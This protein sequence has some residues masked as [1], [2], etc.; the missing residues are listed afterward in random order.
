MKKTTL[1][2]LAILA[3][4]ACH[5]VEDPTLQWEQA[6]LAPP[7]DL[8]LIVANPQREVFFGDLHIHSSYSF[9]AYTMGVRAFPEDAYRFARG[10]QVRHGVGYPVQIDRPLDF[11]AVSDHSE[12]LGIARRQAELDD[13]GKVQETYDEVL[14]TALAGR[15]WRYLWHFMREGIRSS[16]AQARERNF[17]VPELA[18]ASVNAWAD[19][20]RAAQVHNA[21]GRFT[22]FV[23]YEWS[24]MPED[25]HLHRVVLYGDDK[26]PGLPWSS[27]ESEN[28]EDLWKEL[29]RQRDAGH[30]V[31][32]IPHNSNLSNGLMFSASQHSG[33]P[34]KEAL[35]AL[36]RSI[37]PV[38]EIYQVKGQSETHPALSPDDTFADFELV[39]Q[40]VMA[41]APARETRG[42]YARDALRLGME[43]NH[44]AGINPYR[45]GVIGSS[46]SHNATSPVNEA[47]Y[48]GK[49]PLLDGTPGI[50]LGAY[51]KDV[52]EQTT[53]HRWSAMG[54]A[55]VWAPENTR[56]ALFAAMNRKETYA[57]SGS[58]IRLRFFAGDYPDTLIDAADVIEV[59]Y[60][61]GVPMGGE[62]HVSHE[63]P[64]A[65][66]L[67][68][69]K[70]PEG[71]NLDR[72]QVIKAWTDASGQSHEAIYDVAASGDRMRQ[73]GTEPLAPVGNTVDVAR[74]TYSNSIGA[75]ELRVL[76]RDPDYQPGQQALYY[77]RVLEI[78]TPRWSTYDAVTLGVP[79]P[80]PG[81][82]QERAVSSA[83]W[84]HHEG[85]DT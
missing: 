47:T 15:A 61:R 22:A 32:A 63:R 37:E 33:E 34:Y 4:S 16:S 75:T 14:A 20:R 68:A 8:P 17:G 71:A 36:R 45:F 2:F 59:A 40:P 26:V 35:A 83:I 57:T 10:G 3:L 81:W 19:I 28:P 6:E 13:P 43:M 58:R 84:L 62:L 74:A 51:S 50:R 11:A 55:A 66:L 72:I 70:D 52:H 56:S 21:P 60:A 9:D 7:I 1:P 48:H 46:D 85:D 5:R 25:Q 30:E 79:A 76:W 12:Y 23:A 82:I 18:Q 27:L 41:S 54:L 78:P 42:S 49:L 64:P 69:S 24:S 31:I 29:Q 65:F 39:E 44:A 53:M 67:W 80:E 38:V 77:A 73:A